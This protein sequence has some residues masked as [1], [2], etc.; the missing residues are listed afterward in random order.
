MIANVSYTRPHWQFPVTCPPQAARRGFWRVAAARITMGLRAAVAVG[1]LFCR[2]SPVA[3]QIVLSGTSAS[4]N[5]DSMGTSTN[6]PFGWKMSPAGAVAPTYADAGNFTNCTQQS[7]SGSP[8]TGARYNWGSSTSERAAGFM[9]SGSYASPNSI[10]VAYQNNNA[11]AIGSVE[12]S[13]DYERYR[14]NSAAASVTFFYSTDGSVWTSVPSGDSGSFVTGDSIYGYPESTVSKSGVTITGLNIASGQVVYFRWNFNT[15]GGNSQGLGLDN[16][17][18][19]VT[20]AEPAPDAPVVLPAAATNV[21]GFT[22]AW[23]AVGGVTGYALDVSTSPTFFSMITVLNETFERFTTAENTE[24][25]SNLDMY[26]STTGWTGEKVYSASVGGEAKMGTSSDRGVLVTP[27]LDLSG[28]GGNAVL[29]FEA[30]RFGTDSTVIQVFHAADG[31]SFTQVGGDIALSD[32]MTAYAREITGGT[33]TSR[34]RIYPKNSSNYRYYLDNL[35]VTQSGASYVDGYE[36]RSTGGSTSLSVTGLVSGTEYFY[37]V[38]AASAASTSANSTTQSVTTLVMPA[39]TT[40][41]ASSTGALEFVANWTTVPEA[42]GYRLDVST[43][44]T[45]TSFVDGYENLDVTNVTSFMVS[46]LLAQTMYHYRV[47]AYDAGSTSANSATQSVTTTLKGEPSNHAT[48]FTNS[49]P[50]H[51][52]IILTWTDA[53]G[54][55]PPDRYLVRG[56]TN[57]FDAILSPTD[58]SP[59]A[60]NTTDWTSGLYANNVKQG[61]QRDELRGLPAER[62]YYFKLFPFA[63]S[64]SKIDYKTNSPVPQ[65]TFATGAAPLEDFE[66]RTVQSFSNGVVN[67]KSGNW[68]FNDTLLG[69]LSF[70]KRN[71]QRSARIRNLGSITMQ[72]DVSDV[73]KIIFDHANYSNDIGVNFVV[74]MSTDGGSTWTQLGAEI[75]SGSEL[76]AAE[77]LVHLRGT[78]RFRFRKTATANDDN[79][80]NIDN[81]YITPY[82]VP[83]TV[84]RFN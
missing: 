8:T 78:M 70:D 75:T 59:V 19:A 53:T 25:T 6:L 82:R 13:F 9:T 12:L 20:F 54:T 45:F 30:K 33:I 7:S 10:M 57:G 72:F 67:L 17:S 48:G 79:R 23:E 5:F 76:A 21:Q 35:V 80:L 44:G 36:S 34:V 14:I 47:R 58:T 28:R 63:N 32:T 60:N 4:E 84:F 65:L 38:R 73:E 18:M 26:T 61:V 43:N 41:P 11:G 66:D 56:S 49:V 64:H 2:V 52:T 40:L 22:A 15:T 1:F 27:T 50:T 74:E 31:G 55:T 69:T 46:D 29:S 83:P 71:D 42:A 39:P 68:L 37:R 81:V 16:F 24:I 51:R 77:R 3:A 62:T